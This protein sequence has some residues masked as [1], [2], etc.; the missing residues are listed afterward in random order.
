MK[1]NL[2]R[3]DESIQA[4]LYILEQLHGATDMHK[5]CK[6][7]YYADQL[8]LSRYARCITGDV[9]IA[10]KYGPVPSIINDILKAVRGDSYFSGDEFKPYFCFINKYMLKQ[11]QK[12]NLDYLSDTD[13]ECLNEAITLCKDKSFEQLTQ[14]SHGMAY[15]HTT[16]DRTMSF[17]DILREA[18][19]DEEYIEYAT[20]KMKM[21][22]IVFA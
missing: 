2:F 1:T 22:N 14:M 19:D 15:C 11:I 16:P 10:M 8:H 20:R 17:K 6:I 7:L 13:V 18:G 9:Y 21:E 5:V 3:K 4:I 12:P